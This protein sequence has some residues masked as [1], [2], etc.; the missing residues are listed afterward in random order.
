MIC[1]RGALANATTS[2]V[3]ISIFPPTS[4]CT[5][6]RTRNGDVPSI[7]TRPAMCQRYCQPRSLR[8]PPSWALV[9]PIA[10]ARGC[11]AEPETDR[12]PEKLDGS[13]SQEFED[14]DIDRAKEA[15]P[16]VKEYC[17]GAASE[18]QRLG[19]E[20]QV[21]EGGNPIDGGTGNGGLPHPAVEARCRC[22]RRG[23]R[24]A[25]EPLATYAPGARK[26]ELLAL[27]WGDVDLSTPVE[28]C[29]HIR[30]PNATDNARRVHPT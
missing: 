17:G 24:K 22:S 12:T 9:L 28:A 8:R 7:C 1:Q 15:S 29:V 5:L 2:C 18:A 19:C 6:L 4:V 26:S 16:A 11:G 13:P 20:A 21:T 14:E 3:A 10:L 25:A 23:G 30:R 27:R